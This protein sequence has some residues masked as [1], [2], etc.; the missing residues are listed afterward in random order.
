[1][2]DFIPA[3]ASLPPG[4]RVYA[5]GDVHGCLERLQTD[6]VDAFFMHGVE[7]RL[8]PQLLQ[9]PAM[10]AMFEG[11]KKSGKIRYC[12]LS[13]HD[14]ALVEVRRSLALDPNDSWGLLTLGW[15]YEQQGKFQEALAAQRRS[16]DTTI[17][18]GSS[19]T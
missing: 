10:K 6:Y 18:S 1:M 14:K 8:I 19:A 17:R 13:C 7:G 11:L 9:N 16:W 3:P 12:G 4:Q 2:I 5:V 15:I